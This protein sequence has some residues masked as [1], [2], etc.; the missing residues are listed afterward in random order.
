MDGEQRNTQDGER[1]VNQ[2]KIGKALGRGAYA[3]VELGVDVG[4]GTEYVNPSLSRAFQMTQLTLCQAVK[5]FSKSRLHLRALQEKHRQE[6]RIRAKG[7]GESPNLPEYDGKR[8]A[9]EEGKGAG[10]DD[11]PSKD[12][13]WGAAGTDTIEKDP[14][15]LIRRE[16]AVMKKLE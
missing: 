15:G 14:L 10:G 6:T 12:G 3:K 8:K 16:I 2:Y 4:T 7:G 5:E 1:M 11:G 9:G 13:P